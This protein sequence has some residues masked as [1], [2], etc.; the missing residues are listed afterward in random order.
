MRMR[1][2]GVNGDEIL[3]MSTPKYKF[4]GGKIC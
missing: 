4:L 3:L 2:T 1:V